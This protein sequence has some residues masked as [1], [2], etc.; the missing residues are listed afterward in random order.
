MTTKFRPIP[1]IL[2]LLIM[3]FFA[4]MVYATTLAQWTQNT[5]SV[6]IGTFNNVAPTNNGYGISLYHASAIAAGNQSSR[7]LRADGTLWGFGTNGNYELGLG[8]NVFRTSPTQI[9]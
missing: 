1:V 8:D 7:V 4:S 5:F 9:G 2:L 3:G 6:G